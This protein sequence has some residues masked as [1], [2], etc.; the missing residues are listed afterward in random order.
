MRLSPE[1]EAAWARVEAGGNPTDELA[2]FAL[3]PA[4]ESEIDTRCQLLAD[5]LHREAAQDFR[6]ADALHA[7]Y[8]KRNVERVEANVTYLRSEK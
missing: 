6:E 2:G 8:V 1:L 7:E 3:T 4:E 5:K